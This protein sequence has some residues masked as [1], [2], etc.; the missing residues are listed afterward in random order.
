MD[1]LLRVQKQLV[2]QGS[3]AL[4]LTARSMKLVILL[5]SY[6]LI[7]LLAWLK[8]F[9]SSFEFYAQYIGL[10]GWH[11]SKEVWC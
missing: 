7:F 6:L 11:F 3:L 4:I 9:L 1:R 10:L 2:L 8:L 5:S